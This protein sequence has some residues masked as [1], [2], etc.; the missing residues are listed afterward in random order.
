MKELGNTMDDQDSVNSTDSPT[1]TPDMEEFL[2]NEAYRRFDV[3]IALILMLCL[4]IGLPGNLI[5]LFFY[6]CRRDFASLVYSSICGL[7]VFICLISIPVMISLFNHRMPGILANQIF[8]VGWNVVFY[9]LARMSMFLVMLLSVSRTIAI[10]FPFYQMRKIVFLASSG[11]YILIMFIWSGLVVHYGGADMF[12]SYD[13]VNVYCYYE[14]FKVGNSFAQIEQI[15]FVLSLGIPPIVTLI[16]FTISVNKLAR[17]SSVS[18]MSDRNRQA[19]VTLAS[20]TGLFLICNAPCFAN[21]VVYMV[22]SF[23]GIYP[24]PFYMSTFMFFYSWVLAEVVSVVV[25]AAL[26]P[27]LYYFRVQALRQW[28]MSCL[29]GSKERGLGSPSKS[30]PSSRIK[31]NNHM[32]I[33]NFRRKTFRRKTIA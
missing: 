33:N 10:V 14:L 16:S 12:Y 7:D 18:H 11:I 6:S 31:L 5:S 21:N 1:Y 2:S 23:L 15:L 27:V 4:L 20:F 22:G 24:R 3:L 9:F 19:S 8:C 25:N 30:P 29:K 28:T 32:N 13:K 17:K 26:N